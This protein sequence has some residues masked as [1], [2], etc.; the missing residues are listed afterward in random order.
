MLN[1]RW[2]PSESQLN[3]ELERQ[4]EQLRKEYRRQVSNQWSLG[5]LEEL[6]RLLDL[7]E[8]KHLWRY[9]EPLREVLANEIFK[10][11]SWEH[12]QFMCGQQDVINR[13]LNMKADIQSMKDVIRMEN[14]IAE[15]NSNA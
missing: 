14:N 9:L 5:Q 3:E 12:Y 8:A 13:V 7:P 6:S 11:R 1:E 4:Q 2:R 10:A 15:E